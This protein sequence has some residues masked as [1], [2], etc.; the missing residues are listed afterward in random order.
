MYIRGKKSLFYQIKQKKM[1]IFMKKTVKILALILSAAMLFAIVS[2]S[3]G[4]VVGNWKT[5]INSAQSLSEEHLALLKSLGIADSLLSM[6]WTFS[7][8]EDNTF[9]MSVG[10][11]T[12]GTNDLSGQY[13][14]D[15]SKLYLSSDGNW[16][17]YLEFSVSGDKMTFKSLS[18]ESS[19]VGT[20]IT[21]P[22]EFSKID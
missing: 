16:T 17:S 19:F 21:F 10:N 15:G 3:S 18:G 8:K 22:I 1:V 11:E 13:K 12:F 4:S 5:T 14:T 9:E 2:C 20:N 6:D 7:F